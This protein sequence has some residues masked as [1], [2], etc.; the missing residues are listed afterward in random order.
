M[1]FEN[2]KVVISI[3]GLYF[4]IFLILIKKIEEFV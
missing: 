1:D 2:Y 4:E 3:I